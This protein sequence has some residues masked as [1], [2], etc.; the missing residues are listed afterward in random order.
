M[1]RLPH[2]EP[3]L[4]GLVQANCPQRIAKVHDQY[5]SFIALEGRLF[6]LGLPDSYLQLNDPKAQD[7][8]IQV[9]SVN[10]QDC[11]FGGSFWP[12]SGRLLLL[13]HVSHTVHACC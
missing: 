12:L 3:L 6:S 4:A 1:L 11:M 10:A 13:R 8:Q 2:G 9:C 7:T 5:L